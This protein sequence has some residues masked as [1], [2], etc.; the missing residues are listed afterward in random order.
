MSWLRTRCC[1]LA[2]LHC[3][4]I[5]PHQTRAYGY[6][7]CDDPWDPHRPIDIELE[8]L[9]GPLNLS[10]PNLSFES[11]VPADWEM[12]NYPIIEITLS[13]WI[14]ADMHQF[15]LH[16]N[17]TRA[18]DCILTA[19]QDKWSPLTAPSTAISMSRDIRCHDGFHSEGEVCCQ[20]AHNQHARINNLLK[21][22]VTQ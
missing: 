22:G 20:R 8:S 6:G 4:I 18:V 13:T 10:R 9:F 1:G 16:S 2:N 17:P 11:R 7:V 12:L 5:N 15:A 3:S 14:P 19:R 21:H